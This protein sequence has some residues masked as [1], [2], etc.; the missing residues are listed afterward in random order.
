MSHNNELD[1][2]AVIIP[3]NSLKCLHYDPSINKHKQ[4]KLRLMQCKLA[5]HKFGD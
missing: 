4:N 5:L 3:K 2:G 1:P